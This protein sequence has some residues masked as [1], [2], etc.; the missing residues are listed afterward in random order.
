M[1]STKT[2]IENLFIEL[3]RDNYNPKIMNNLDVDGF[4]KMMKE[5]LTERE[6][7][8]ISSRCAIGREKETYI[9]IARRYGLMT[10]GAIK[11]TESKAIYKLRHPKNVKAFLNGTYGVKEEPKPVVKP[12]LENAKLE[13]LKLTAGAFNKLRRRGIKTVKELCNYTAEEITSI[14]LIGPK[15]FKE[16]TDALK[17]EYNV[18]LK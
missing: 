11:Q 18:T 10:G 4:L 14:Y 8:I 17:R 6:Y 13:D 9:S 2:G 5:V 15:V 1:N 16:I 7:D 3:F 12:D